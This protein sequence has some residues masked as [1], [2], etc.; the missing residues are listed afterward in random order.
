M[1]K[2]RFALDLTW[3]RHKIVGGT[4]AF[5]NNL[6]AGF[7]QT[8]TDFRLVLI[9]AKDNAHLFEKYLTDKRVKIEVANVR[10]DSVFKRIIWQNLHL[11]RF[12]LQ[13]G[14]HLCLEPV[15]AKP[16][17]AS[18]K[19]KW[20]TVIHD[21]E[22]THFPENHSFITNLWLRLSWYD[23]VHTSSHVVS[24]S[25]FVRDDIMD[26]Y[27]IDGDRITTIYNP[28]TLDVNE[29]CSFEDVARKYG[30][31]PKKY[32]YTVSKLNPHKNLSTLVRVFGEIKRRQI[33]NIPCK[34]LISGINGGMAGE[35]HKL[36][37]EYGLTDNE[38]VLTGFVNDDVRNCLYA[39]AKAFLF[40]SIFEG[41]GMP[42]IEAMYYGTPVVTTLRASIP[43][44]TQH[45]AGY[46]ADPHSVEDWITAVGHI[47]NNDNV[48]LFDM[49]RYNPQIVASQYIR[50]IES[51]DALNE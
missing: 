40:P 39:N 49:G 35:L 4:E 33:E 24:I 6:I 34:L 38:L 41:F 15:Y 13:R 36:M 21:L 10:S 26:C 47:D 19:I 42:P 3:V 46:V 20:I 29:M 51:V 17:F 7:L 9:V 16:L 22:A 48:E 23:A 12:I 14:I 45:V 5:V 18:N 11:S 31:T 32:Y 27:H 2:I 30:I 37:E 1:S 50:V 8:E 43:E 25:D 44:V 28:I